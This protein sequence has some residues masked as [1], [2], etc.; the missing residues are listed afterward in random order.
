MRIGLPVRGKYDVGVTQERR[1][2][3]CSGKSVNLSLVVN[4]SSTHA[5]HQSGPDYGFVE[6]L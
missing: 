6:I 1:M 4:G 2:K 3:K 5:R